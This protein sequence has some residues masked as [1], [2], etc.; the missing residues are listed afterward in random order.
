MSIYL[1]LMSGTSVDAVDAVLARFEPDFELLASHSKPI[2]PALK[3][4]ILALAGASMYGVDDFGL[5]DREL[6]ELFAETATELISL[7]GIPASRITAIGSHG[8]TVRHR[9]GQ[10]FTLQIGDP[11][12]IAE[13]TG[14]TTIADFR[15]RDVAAG[16]QGAPLVPAFH[17]WLFHAPDED[18]VIVN[19]GGMANLTCLAADTNT[20][21]TGFDTGPG[22]ALLDEW[23]YREQGL[24]FDA[25]GDWASAGQVIPALLESML[26]T[27]FFHQSAPKSTGRE[28]FNWH[29][30]EHHVDKLS[31]T[32]SAADIQATLTELTAHT[33]A[34]AVKWLPLSSP[35]LFVC[36][37]GVHNGFL[38]TRIADRLPGSR[39]TSTAE[40][41]LDPDWVEAAAFAW[42]AWRTD[43]RQS[44]NL[45]EVTGAG[46]ER[47]LGAIY[48]A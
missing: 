8:Q 34:E 7:S 31:Q 1:G 12:R 26:T 11:S 18:R 32:A 5:L 2:K 25:N 21:V 42:L 17:R 46:G 6:G 43:R 35:T 10:G 15:R 20:R 9:P 30:V 27:P 22:N 41:K 14:L 45:P 48:P 38:L 33:I 40:L 39:I 29:W 4:R 3:Q 13:Q 47:I 23:I 37:G 16:G 44:G 24:T 28:Q 19:I 36:G